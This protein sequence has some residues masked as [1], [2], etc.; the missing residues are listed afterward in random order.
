MSSELP[1]EHNE[2]HGLQ[3]YGFRGAGHEE[4]RC[5]AQGQ[6]ALDAS[7]QTLDCRAIKIIMRLG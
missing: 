3:T 4:H 2:A 6:R 7:Q 5:S 1:S